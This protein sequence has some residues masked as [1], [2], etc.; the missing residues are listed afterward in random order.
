MRMRKSILHLDSLPP[1]DRK[2]LFTDLKNI[3]GG[4]LEDGELCSSHMDCCGR[5]CKYTP[6]LQANIG[7]CFPND[8]YS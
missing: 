6:N 5:Y 1:R 4:C 7:I 3:F 2:V 8:P